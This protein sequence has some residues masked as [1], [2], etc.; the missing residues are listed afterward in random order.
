MTFHERF[1]L[2]NG[3][4]RIKARIVGATGGYAGAT[5]HVIFVG[6]VTPATNGFG[7]YHGRWRL[8]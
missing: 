8:P 2:A 7:S 1:A 5:G 3:H 6:T 4:I